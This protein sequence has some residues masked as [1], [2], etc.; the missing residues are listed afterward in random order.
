MLLCLWVIPSTFVLI[1]VD[2]IKHPNFIGHPNFIKSTSQRH[3][4]ETQIRFIHFWPSRVPVLFII[5]KIMTEYIKGLNNLKNSNNSVYVSYW[6]I[7]IKILSTLIIV[8][9]CK[10]KN[11][12]FLFQLLFTCGMSCI[13]K[14]SWCSSVLLCRITKLYNFHHQASFQS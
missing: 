14:K 10:T 9:G 8:V 5:F 6:F 4:Y 3:T 7:F 12:K 2:C 11:L 1:T 13:Q